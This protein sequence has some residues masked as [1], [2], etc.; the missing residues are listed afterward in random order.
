MT[1]FILITSNRQTREQF[2][3]EFARK[4]QIDPFDITTIS[5]DETSKNT[6]SLGIDDIKAMQKKI[7]LKPFKSPHK[8]IVLHD[9]NLLTIEAQNALLKV[10]EEPPANTFIILTSPTAETFLPTILSRCSIIQQEEAP[11][12]LTTEESKQYVQFLTDLTK[13]RIGDRLKK[14]E[15]LAKNKE[16]ALLWLQKLTLATRQKLLEA[17]NAKRAHYYADYINHFQT[18]YTQIK[19]TNVNLRFALEHMLLHSK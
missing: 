9:A 19:T 5:K 3:Q 1:S 16:E 12:T 17:P 8:M 4:Q 10:L 15:Q 18:T 13:M 11:P 7:F 14:A 6:H 2:L